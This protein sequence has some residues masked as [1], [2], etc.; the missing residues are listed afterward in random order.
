[1]THKRT[2]AIFGLSAVFGLT[3]N[4][5][6]QPAMQALYQQ[7]GEIIFGQ[8]GRGVRLHKAYTTQDRARFNKAVQIYEEYLRQGQT[9]LVVPVIDD[10]ATVDL[11][12]E[13]PAMM[14]RT[15]EPMEP[16]STTDYV[17][18][19]TDVVSTE[20]LTDEQR[21]ILTRS[22]KVG[23]CWHF[24]KFSAGFAV[25]CEKLIRGTEEKSTTGIQN[26]LVEIK[27]KLRMGE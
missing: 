9:D 22:I 25:L 21:A 18:D 27:R 4:S 8:D 16:L 5:I 3:L 26:D 20:A 24:A 12:L 11:Y 23:K 2:I 17:P 19:E 10:P 15:R 13:N 1:M 14:D 6:A 7:N